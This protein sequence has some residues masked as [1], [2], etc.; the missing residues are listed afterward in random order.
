MEKTKVIGD[1]DNAAD[2][3]SEWRVVAG[4]YRLGD[5]YDVMYLA[6]V[7]RDSQRLNREIEL[8]LSTDTNCYGGVDLWCRYSARRAGASMAVGFVGEVGKAVRRVVDAGGVPKLATNNGFTVVSGE[9]FECPDFGGEILKS[10][11]AASKSAAESAA[12]L[13]AGGSG[14]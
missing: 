13:A 6:G 2:N 7:I 4:P 8:R 9:F 3:A 14:L 10:A 5:A 12:E 11:A 1:V